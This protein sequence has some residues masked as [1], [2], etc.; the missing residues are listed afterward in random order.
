MGIYTLV[1][2]LAVLTAGIYAPTL[3]ESELDDTVQIGALVPITGSASTHG[4][5]IRIAIE[6]AESDFNQYLQEIN[7][8]WTL[9]VLIEDS[10]TNPVVALDKLSSMNAK[11]I[12]SVVGTYSSAELRNIKGYSD[13]NGMI[14]ISY[15]SVAPSLAI[16]NDSIFRFVPDDTNNGPVISKMFEISG[17]TNVVPIW[18]G[19]AW[20]DGLVGNIRTNFEA[21]GGVMDEGIRYNPEAIEFSTEVALLS[22]FVARHTADVG[23][24]KVAV[25][26]VSFSEVTNLAQSASGYDNLAST[27]WFGTDAIVG[28]DALV[29]DPIISTFF[30]SAGLTTAQFAPSQN[31][32]YK[33]VS[34]TVADI[35]GRTPTVYALPAY[36]AVWVLGLSILSTDSTDTQAIKDEMPRVLEDYEGAIGKIVLNEAGD[37]AEGTFEIWDVMGSEWVLT[38]TYDA[39]SDSIILQDDA[40]MEDEMMDDAM[41]EDEMMDDTMM[42]DTM[43]DDT[44]MD[45]TMMDDTMMDD[46]M[47]DDTMMDDTMMEDEMKDDTMVED[48]EGG[49]CLIATAAYGSE[50]STQVQL[51]REIRDDTL[52]QTAA[53][54]SFMTGFNQFYYSFSPAVADLERENQ[55]VRD[56]TR[57]AITPAIYALGIM[58]HADSETTVLIFGI[59]TL[60]VIAG[61]YLAPLLAAYVVARRVKRIYSSP[62][63]S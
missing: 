14:L 7:A 20:G 3:A 28:I 62:S 47:M 29:T 46:T 13:N 9:D 21:T 60:F 54:T 31:P 34:A 30:D 49:G 8:G 10:A 25:M 32:T 43:M 55:A 52:Y 37:L 11:G 42:D 53:G 5:D 23:A 39:A 15:G 33:R 19:D 24:D 18:R 50:L 57:A 27:K 12:G 26:T 41:M 51:L 59:I 61:I 63:S 35:S 38:G 4:E 36:D 17:I 40:M 58:T 16:P 1:V 56:V 44:M 45:D 6:V 48:E 2:L 22:E